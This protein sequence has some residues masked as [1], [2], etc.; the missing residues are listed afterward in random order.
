MFDKIIS[1][2][3]LW[4]LWQDVE[5]CAQDQVGEEKGAGLWWLGHWGGKLADHG[6]EHCRP[7]WRLR[8]WRPP[9]KLLRSPSRLSWWHERSQEV[10][11]KLREAHQ[12]RRN[13]HHWSQVCCHDTLAVTYNLMINILSE[14]MITFWPMEK[15]LPRISI[16]TAITLMTSRPASSTSTTSPT[17]SHWTTSWMWIRRT[18]TATSSGKSNRWHKM[19]RIIFQHVYNDLGFPTIHTPLTASQ[20]YSRRPSGKMPSTL[21]MQIS[22]RWKMN[23]NQAFISMSL[24]SQCE[25][26]KFNKCGEN[27]LILW[28]LLT[29]ILKS[30][31]R[32][33]Q[34]DLCQ[35]TIRKVESGRI[36]IELN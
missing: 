2:D 34:W 19:T 20:L 9:W 5:R 15:L 29:F 25:C 6:G 16:T 27:I 26:L 17:S 36:G 24:K 4:C 11:G 12:T 3:I 7:S 8:C 21:F 32:H 33:R 22:S 35:Y 31:F 23:Q 28:S 14:T 1:G 10:H 18:Q 13:L 30:A